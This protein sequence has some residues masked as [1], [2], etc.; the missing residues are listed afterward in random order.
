MIS[1]PARP[2]APCIQGASKQRPA[3]AARRNRS[4]WLPLGNHSALSCQS[5]QGLCELGRSTS[6][7][8]RGRRKRLLKV[9]ASSVG[10]L[11]L[12]PGILILDPTTSRG[13]KAFG[14]R[15]CIQ[16]RGVSQAVGV[17]SDE[18]HSRVT[19]PGTWSRMARQGWGPG[20]SLG[21]SQLT[22]AAWS[23]SSEPGAG[24]GF[25]PRDTHPQLSTGL[26][27]TN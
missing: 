4:V 26:L 18:E 25:S 5:L 3:W 22:P 16:G 15:D 11:H 19:G 17:R 24:A 27:P 2:T 7:N 8:T 23:Y 12:H 6:Q 20:S 14:R 10:G 21:Q 13:Q 9:T 1:S